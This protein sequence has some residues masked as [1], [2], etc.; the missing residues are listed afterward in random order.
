MKSTLLHAAALAAGLYAS[1]SAAQQTC[2]NVLV[3]TYAAPS[4]AS[5]WTAQLVA[6]GLTQPRSI[7]FDGTGALLVVESGRGITRIVF[8]DNG[9]T[10]LEVAA[11]AL[12]VN[13]TT[14]S[15]LSRVR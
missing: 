2:Q 13:Q 4:V 12:I 11:S 5:G 7:L 1:A 10:C 6:N 3:P 14:V 15:C 9:G 8:K